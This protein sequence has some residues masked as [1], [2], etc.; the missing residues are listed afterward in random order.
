METELELRDRPP[1]ASRKALVDELGAGEGFVLYTVYRS[2]SGA[3]ESG[4]AK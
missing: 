4:F 3:S 1:E 2:G